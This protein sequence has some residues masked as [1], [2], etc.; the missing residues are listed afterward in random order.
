ML[1]RSLAFCLPV[2]A[3][4]DALTAR[5]H[6]HTHTLLPGTC[7]AVVFVR[8]TPENV[9]MLVSELGDPLYQ[10]YNLF[11]SNVLRDSQLQQLANA[12]S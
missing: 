9:R 1:C 12:G 2:L 10:E 11:F 4:S 3:T 7:Q 5:P 6:T 8:P